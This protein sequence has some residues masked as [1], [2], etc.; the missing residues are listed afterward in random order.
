MADFPYLWIYEN[1]E[2]Q[3]NG[4]A[5]GQDGN[6]YVQGDVIM[7]GESIFN[8]FKNERNRLRNIFAKKHELIPGVRANGDWNITNFKA[9]LMGTNLC[10]DFTAKTK[11]KFTVE[12]LDKNNADMFEVTL[13]HYGYIKNMAHVS[14]CNERSGPCSAMY[15]YG[16]GV[17]EQTLDFGVRLT[18]IGSDLGQGKAISA[19]FTIPVSLNIKNFPTTWG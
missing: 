15:T 19:K 12:D 10:I 3:V 4:K 6:L 11:K 5:N 14:F 1:N 13:S 16:K 18:S 17:G 8:T 7:N 2:Q 9:E